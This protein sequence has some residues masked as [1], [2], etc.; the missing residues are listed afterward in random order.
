MMMMMMM[1]WAGDSEE[2]LRSLSLIL[3]CF[4]LFVDLNHDVS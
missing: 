4:L 1:P 2:T 3:H